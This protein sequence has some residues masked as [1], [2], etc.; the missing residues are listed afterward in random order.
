MVRPA[1]VISSYPMSHT[2]LKQRQK[3]ELFLLICSLVLEPDN[4][5]SLSFDLLYWKSRSII[6]YFFQSKAPS[7]QWWRIFVGLFLLVEK[8]VPCSNLSRCA[9][10]ERCTYYK[11]EVVKGRDDRRRMKA[12]DLSR[13]SMYNAR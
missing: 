5:A 7:G 1:A 13:N 2:H 3:F 11:V 6:L 10:Q 9:C 12:H 4:K 8:L